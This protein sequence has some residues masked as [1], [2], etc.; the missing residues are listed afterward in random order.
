M[1]DLIFPEGF[2]YDDK[3]AAAEKKEEQDYYKIKRMSNSSLKYFIQS[4]RHYLHYLRTP[5]QDTPATILGRAFHCLILED[6]LFWDQFF[7]ID[8]SKRA[9]LEHGMT[10]KINLR[11]KEFQIH[12]NVTKTLI[13][14]QILDTCQR[15]RDAVYAC[16]PA[17][18]LLEEITET[19]KS[20]FWLDPET[21]IKMKGKLDGT[22]PSITIDLKS[23]MDAKPQAFANHA[24]SM[25]Y[26][27][28]AA[29]YSDARPIAKDQHGRKV[30]LSKG[31]FYFIACE[32][33]APY[34]VS[35]N[36]ASRSFLSAGR[37]QY[38]QALQDYLYWQ[39]MGA[40]DVCYE[41]RTPFGYHALNAPRWISR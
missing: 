1:E 19:E 36:K 4:P 16:P 31:E 38:S 33:E 41:W 2:I 10:S 3:S 25:D 9:D 37:N 8:E 20:L 28:Q 11:W 6:H 21:G 22:S 27:Q 39:E 26:H 24:W 14:E 32:K 5:W 15:M 30:N 34:G 17:R 40:P 7:I 13:T 18:E 12:R 23:C 29:L 35:V